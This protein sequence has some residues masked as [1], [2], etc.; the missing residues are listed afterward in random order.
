MAEH[1][2]KRMKTI[3]N[4]PRR[5]FE[6]RGQSSA[7]PRRPATSPLNCKHQGWFSFTAENW[8]MFW[9]VEEGFQFPH[10][11]EV[12]GTNT[13]IGLHGKLYPSLIRE[14]YSNFVYKNDQYI[15][16]VKGK[17]IM[18]DEELFLAVGDLSSS[19]TYR[20]CLRDTITVTPGGLTT[21]GSLTVENR[22][23]QYVIA[24][25]LVQQNT[26]HAQPTTNDLKII[27]AI[28][29]GI[30]VNW[31]AEILKLMSGNTTSSSRLLAYGIFISRI[32]DHM[33]IDT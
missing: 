5:T 30:L 12:Q 23:L 26:N 28:K 2:P 18:L 6:T 4:H 9:L 27:F 21:V 15:T 11:L 1:R 19:A 33:E 14:F 8:L 31:P 10:E 32:I 22:L 3:A 13:F 25:M 7:T 24:Y 20:S 29:Q 17:L 16:M